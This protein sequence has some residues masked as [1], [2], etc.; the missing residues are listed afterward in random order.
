MLLFRR[1]ETHRFC[2]SQ[3][4]FLDSAHSTHLNRQWA[5]IDIQALARGYVVRRRVNLARFEPRLVATSRSGFPRGTPG[6]RR[7]WQ[8]RLEQ[9]EFLF[10]DRMELRRQIGKLTSAHPCLTPHEA[11]LAIAE[12]AGAS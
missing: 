9:C 11:F 12:T 3:F 10:A 4:I 8:R 2:I 5:A 6:H 1:L 7:H